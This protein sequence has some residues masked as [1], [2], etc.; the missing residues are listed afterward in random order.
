[1]A[2]VT[3]LPTLDGRDGWSIDLQEVKFLFIEIHIGCY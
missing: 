2:H 3:Y 1:M